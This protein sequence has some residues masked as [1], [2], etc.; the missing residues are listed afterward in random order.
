MIV[1][2]QTTPKVVY[3]IVYASLAL[4]IST[5]IFGKDQ[6]VDPTDIIDPD[7][8]NL[9]NSHKE[10]LIQAFHLDKETPYPTCSFTLDAK[11]EYIPSRVETYDPWT[12]KESPWTLISIKGREPKKR[13]HKKNPRY[14]RTDPVTAWQNIRDLIKWESL[15]SLEET[16]E[17]LDISGLI[18]LQVGKNEMTD[19]NVKIR[20]RKE[21]ETIE[22]V[23]I[24]LI[25]S[26]KINFAATIKD[27]TMVYNYEHSDELNFPLLTALD[28]DWRFKF[29]LAPALSKENLVYLNYD[30]P[31]EKQ[32]S[33][34][35]R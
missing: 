16:E 1:S 24:T 33:L 30:C 29:F 19:A 34:C 22:N 26:H 15:S 32:L 17:Y 21:L 10:L 5:A 25:K 11:L 14:T 28:I 7:V 13:E 23:T 6:C 12:E 31:K 2:N 4:S 35:P 9:S 18:L 3:L 27:M 8:P 20:I